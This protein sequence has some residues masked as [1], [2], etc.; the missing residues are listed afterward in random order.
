MGWKPDEVEEL[1][2]GWRREIKYRRSRYW[3][4]PVPR[5]VRIYDEQGVL[6]E[7]WHEVIDGRGNVVHRHRKE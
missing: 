1:P 6:R 4:P 7:I 5:M 3:Q 2:N